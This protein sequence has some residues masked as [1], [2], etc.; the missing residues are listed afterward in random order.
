[1]FVLW[2]QLPVMCC[3]QSAS[4]WFSISSSILCFA[5]LEGSAVLLCFVVLS[6]FLCILAVVCVCGVFSL[7]AYDVCLQRVWR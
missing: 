5:V 4:L 2:S 3:F 6:C 7:S 1:M